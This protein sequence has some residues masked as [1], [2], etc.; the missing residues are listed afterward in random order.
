[1]LAH[2]ASAA[3]NSSGKARA[4][5]HDANDEN[6]KRTLRVD[7]RQLLNALLPLIVRSLTARGIDVID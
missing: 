7:M 5:M 1:V 3:T 2:A 4:V 6:S